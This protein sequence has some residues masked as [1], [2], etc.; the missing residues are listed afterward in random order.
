V[1][2]LLEELDNAGSSLPANAEAW[3]RLLR[4]VRDHAAQDAGLRQSA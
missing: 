2:S 4:Y 1:A 3:D